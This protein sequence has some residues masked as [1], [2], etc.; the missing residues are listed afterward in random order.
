M[1][2]ELVGKLLRSCP[3]V[4]NIYLLVCSTKGKVMGSVYRK[5]LRTGVWKLNFLLFRPNNR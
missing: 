2:K 1:G 5:S 3:H 4:C